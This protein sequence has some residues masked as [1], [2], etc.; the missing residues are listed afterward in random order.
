MLTLDD[1]MAILTTGDPPQIET[2][3]NARYVKDNQFDAIRARSRAAYIHHHSYVREDQEDIRDIEYV[4]FPLRALERT[5]THA[6]HGITRAEL[7]DGAKIVHK[8]HVPYGKKISG[9]GERVTPVACSI[10]VEFAKEGQQDISLT[11]TYQR[12]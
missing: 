11:F 8:D 1:I 5:I 6:L 7:C 3:S 9:Q 4:I 10:L 12:K 2:E